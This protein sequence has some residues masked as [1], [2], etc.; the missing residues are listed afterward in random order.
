QVHRLE[1]D[2]Q[3]FGHDQGIVAVLQPGALLGYGHR[4]LVPLLHVQP[5]KQV[6]LFLQKISGNTGIH[7]PG[8]SDN[9]LFHAVCL[10]LQKY[11][12]CVYF[13]FGPPMGAKLTAHGPGCPALWGSS[14]GQDI[15]STL[16]SIQK[17]PLRNYLF[18]SRGERRIFVVPNLT[19][20]YLCSEKL[21]RPLR[22]GSFFILAGLYLVR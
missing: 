12:M 4:L 14:W 3:F 11:E 13:S 16:F 15:K 7:S 19:K 17:S 8:K 10:C 20:L 5:D 1:G 6:A 2:A 9:D 22:R 18:Y 21:P